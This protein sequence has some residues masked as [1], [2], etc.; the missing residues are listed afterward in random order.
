MSR[1]PENNFLPKS[2]RYVLG[3]LVVGT[4][5]TI[6]V[7]MTKQAQEYGIHDIKQ[8]GFLLLMDFVGLGMTSWYLKTILQQKES[9]PKRRKRRSMPDW[10]RTRDPH[11]GSRRR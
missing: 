6:A 11:R 1:R 8:M 3:G 10:M 7:L 5:D 9:A 2:A 4:Y